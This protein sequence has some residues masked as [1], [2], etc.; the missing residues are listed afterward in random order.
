[1]LEI[2]ESEE[3]AL[4]LNSPDGRGELVGKE[5]YKDDMRKLLVLF[6]QAPPVLFIPLVEN[7]VETW[8]RGLVVNNLGAF[9]RDLEQFGG[10]VQDV[11]PG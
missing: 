4:S 10:Q 8:R 1:M 9:L 7:L 11:V 5:F 2:V 6:S 3:E